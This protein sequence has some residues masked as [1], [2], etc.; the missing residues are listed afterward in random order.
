[1]SRQG[2]C[3]EKCCTIFWNGCQTEFSTM[4]DSQDSEVKVLINFY[5]SGI[6]PELCLTENVTLST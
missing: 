2:N 3:G 4:N 1:M 6:R 5:K